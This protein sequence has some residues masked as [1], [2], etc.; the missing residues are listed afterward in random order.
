M[1]VTRRRMLF[2]I[3][4]RMI[5]IQTGQTMLDRYEVTLSRM[6]VRIVAAEKE[7]IL[8]ILSVCLQN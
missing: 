8:F 1:S 5:Y 4:V 6:R 3:H 2:R 7:Q